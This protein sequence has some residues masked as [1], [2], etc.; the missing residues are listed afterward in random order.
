MNQAAELGIAVTVYI[1]HDLMHL[2]KAIMPY[3]TAI[4]CG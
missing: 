1:A 2:I 3:S 4:T